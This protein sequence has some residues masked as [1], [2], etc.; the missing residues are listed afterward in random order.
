MSK[1]VFAVNK[2]NSA[3]KLQIIRVALSQVADEIH[4][5]GMF[6]LQQANEHNNI[7]YGKM[8]IEALGKKADVKRVEKWLL[9]FGKFGMKGNEL[10]FRDR[11]DIQAEK[12]DAMLE[13]A[14][15]MPWY[16]YSDVE[17]A[18]FKVDVLSILKGALAKEKKAAQLQAE[19]KEVEVK[20]A[21]LFADIAALVAKMETPAQPPVATPDHGTV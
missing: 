4:E 12:I 1:I 10:V 18:T 9:A 8:L 21:N 11:K 19:G 13:K 14:N 15:A 6:A 17:H 5:Y 20:H 7:T 2:E 16:D 3:T